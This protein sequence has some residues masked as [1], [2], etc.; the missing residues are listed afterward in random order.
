MLNFT[1][2]LISDAGYQG[3]ITSVSTA[4]HQI[5][6]FSRVLKTSVTGFLEE[7]EVMMDTNL[8]EFAKMVNHGQH[9][10]LYAQCLLAS[11]CQDS[12]R[13][14]QLKRIGQEVQK[15]AVE[16][17]RDVTQITLCLNG[18]PSYPRVCSAL[19]SMLG[20]N[21]LNPGDITVLYKFY[22]SEDPPPCDLLR[23][24]QFLDL[25]I[26]A[27]FKPT[28]Q[29]NREHKF[30]YIYLL[31]FASCVHEMWQENHRLSLN[32]DELKATSQ[33]IDKVHNICMQESSGASHLSSE[34]G[35]LFQCIRYPVVAMGILKWVDYT[36]SDPSFFKL[37]TDSTPVH[38]S[39]LDE[40]VT[41]HPLQHR[42]VLNLLIRLFESPT[43][44]DTLVELE[45]KKTVL[46][47]MVHM[48]SRGYVIPVISY[49]NKCMKGQDTDNSL[50][51]HFVTEV[52]EMIA[53]PY[54][55]EFIQ[56]F[57]P[58][59]QNKHITGK[60]RKNEGSDDVSA[61]I[62]HCPRDVS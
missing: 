13:G 36:V 50:I 29:I 19:S 51:R 47:R 23:I 43:P 62:A 40:L 35:T 16:S 14:V 9:T 54:S 33:A 1:I 10:Y 26:D 61:F 3:E 11:I 8:P 25:L 24:P 6:V 52:L 5:E 20:K 58:I 21:S 22:S 7:G 41:C 53:P 49:I 48:L 27:L 2:K 59:V 45:F 15:K 17:G 34:V 38:L 37:M 42:L 31:A 39:L 28:Q 32:V 12:L 30:K 44:L 60:L 57:L 56:L 55:P 46:D 18:T 4:C